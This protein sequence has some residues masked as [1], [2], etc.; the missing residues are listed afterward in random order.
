MTI[1]NESAARRIQRR[2]RAQIVI[3][4]ALFSAPVLLAWVVYVGGWQPSS[5]SNNGELLQPAQALAPSDWTTREGEPFGRANLV[6]YWNLLLVV[7]GRCDP[8]CMETLDL[9]RRLRIA[10]GAN[11]S[12]MHLL[13]LQPQ[14]APPPDLPE[15]ANPVVFELLAPEPSIVSLLAKSA[16]GEDAERGVFIVDY[17]A[18][19]MMTYPLP[20]DGSGM[21]D[22]VEHLLRVSNQQSEQAERELLLQSQ[23][24]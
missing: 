15:A 5:T 12:R 23:D 18:F 4:V 9:L 21:L 13:L 2:T 14:G 1:D 3:I 7:D 16:G 20:L 19:N 17:R 10:L 22:D 11:A 24:S 6:G 8:S